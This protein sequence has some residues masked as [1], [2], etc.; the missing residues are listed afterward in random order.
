M[1]IVGLPFHLWTMEKF[2]KIGVVFSKVVAIEEGT[3]NLTMMDATRIKIELN[4]NTARSIM[5]RMG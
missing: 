5:E 1:H 2:S 4:R 3:M